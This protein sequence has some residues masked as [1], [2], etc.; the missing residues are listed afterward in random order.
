MLY[1]LSTN[2]FRDKRRHAARPPKKTSLFLAP[3]LEKRCAVS[4]LLASPRHVHGDKG[5]E[6]HKWGL[7]IKGDWAVDKLVPLEV[8][9]EGNKENRGSTASSSLI[10]LVL[11]MRLV[12]HL[13]CLLW[14]DFELA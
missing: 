14:R 8:I 10:R 2:L 13:R 4:L 5:P 11:A 6:T 7:G 12:D 1:W 9:K 3:R